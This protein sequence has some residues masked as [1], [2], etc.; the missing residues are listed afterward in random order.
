MNSEII[1]AYN[2]P[3]WDTSV[4]ANSVFL[5][6]MLAKQGISCDRQSI[7]K[8][9]ENTITESLKI[10]Q[11]RSDVI[12]ICS[13][14][15]EAENKQISEITARFLGMDKEK[16]IYEKDKKIYVVLPEKTDLLQQIYNKTVQAY[17][18]KHN[19]E[20]GFSK[21]I[22]LCGITESLAYEMAKDL[23]ENDKNPLVSLYSIGGEVHINVSAQGESEEACRKIIKPVVKEL[24]SR[25]G[26]NIYSTDENISL[27]NCVVDLL[28]ENE[29]I[30]TTAES[31]TGGMLSSRII[32]V[33]G[34][35]EMFNEG[36][37]TYS[38][39]AKHKYL[40]VKK[41][42]L[43]KHGAVSSQCAEEMAKGG[44]KAAKADVCVAVTGLA[45]PDG[46]TKEKPVG[47]VFIGV[48]VKGEVTVR[49]YKFSGNRTMIRTQSAYAAL[50][51]LRECLLDYFSKVT[52]KK[53]KKDK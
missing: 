36:F 15:S 19:N 31:C 22:K 44:C 33:P 37:I 2:E 38:N 20:A 48:C 7:V 40:G 8:C 4:C 5:K 3:F 17:L 53:N 43:Q 1:F 10:A 12:V 14:V 35:S 46:G 18:E 27:E 52:L 25:F 41:S 13:G 30:L 51:L 11:S 32:N 26:F 34:A 23:L 47:L 50:T 6:G 39:K 29:L 28:R 16:V 9:D 24:K 21:I 42:T 45:G 49:E